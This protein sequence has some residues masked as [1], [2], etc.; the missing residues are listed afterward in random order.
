[1]CG[2]LKIIFMLFLKNISVLTLL[3][4]IWVT[5]VKTQNMR[6][7]EQLS[8]GQAVSQLSNALLGSKNWFKLTAW[9]REEEK[10]FEKVIC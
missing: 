2:L 7:W 1:M 3:E 5:S 8:V 10:G 6:T 9:M 4:I